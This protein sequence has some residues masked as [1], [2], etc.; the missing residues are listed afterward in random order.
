MTAE[1]WQWGIFRATLD[2]AAGSEQA[3]TR[4]IL[5]VSCES[6]NAV[7]PVVT[8]LPL[9]TYRGGRVYPNEILLPRGTAG[10]PADSLI[11]AYQ[12][13]TVAKS[14][15]NGRYG[16]LADDLL[17]TRVR[18]ALMFHLDLESEEYPV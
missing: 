14:R 15:L 3:G 17:R 6:F 13:R 11:L 5:V 8:V 12:V 4:P 18:Q 10:L 1:V 9:T 7:M 16:L 2:P